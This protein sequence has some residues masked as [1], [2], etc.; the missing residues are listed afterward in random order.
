MDVKVVTFVENDK[1]MGM[2]PYL[3]RLN[4]NL[5]SCPHRVLVGNDAENECWPLI[6]ADLHIAHRMGAMKHEIGI[7]HSE[8]E[9]KIG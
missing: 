3:F 5:K 6:L 7:D 9:D 8:K 1:E 2:V 4:T